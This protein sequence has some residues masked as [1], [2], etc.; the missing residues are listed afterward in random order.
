MSSERYN[1][2][3]EMKLKAHKKAELFNPEKAK[4]IHHIVPKSL[5]QKY[6]LPPDK[7][8]SEDNAIALE[9]DFHNWIHGVRLPKEE[10]I[11]LMDGDISELSKQIDDNEIEWKGFDE[12]DFKFF[13]IALLGMS[14]EDFNKPKKVKK[15]RKRPAL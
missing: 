4:S 9:T 14:E 6:N 15:R 10:L 8:R 1:F 7:I 2:S 3:N 11:E 12:D 13:A 5:A